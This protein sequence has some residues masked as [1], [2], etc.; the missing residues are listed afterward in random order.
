MRYIEM[1]KQFRIGKNEYYII[2]LIILLCCSPL[3]W[4]AGVITLG[5]AIF[6]YLVFNNGG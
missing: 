6:A 2:S 4:W 3:V 5:D 1:M